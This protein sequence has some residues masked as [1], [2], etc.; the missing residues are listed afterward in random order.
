MILGDLVDPAHAAGEPQQ[1]TDVLFGPGQHAGDV[2]DPRRPEP[3]LRAKQGSNVR[4]G[5]LVL[6]GQAHG[7]AGQ[8]DERPVPPDLGQEVR[9]QQ[10]RRKRA[11]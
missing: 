2:T 4:P 5:V 10:R 3:G 6:R 8:T 9:M 7:V 1:A 11:G